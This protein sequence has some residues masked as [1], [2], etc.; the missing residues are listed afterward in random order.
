M[1]K[2]YR[3]ILFLVLFSFS[4]FS[5][6]L[7]LYCK[8]TYNDYSLEIFFSR[9]L[10][11]ISINLFFYSLI[12]LIDIEYYTQVFKI[13]LIVIASI[14]LFELLTWAYLNIIPISLQYGTFWEIL[15]F[16]SFS[17]IGQGLIIYIIYYINESTAKY[18][19][20]KVFGRYHL[21]EG[22]FGVLFIVIALILLILRSSLLFLSDIL[23]KRFSIILLLVQVFLFIFLYIGSFLIFRDWH[24]VRKFR[25]IDK[26]Y[27]DNDKSSVNQSSIFNQI[28]QDDLP[29]FEFPRLTY[30][31]FGIIL[32][33]FALNTIIYGTI[34]L[35]EEIFNLEN[36]IIILLGYLTSFIAGGLIGRDWLRLFRKLYPHLYEEL[37]IAINNLKNTM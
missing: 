23:W 16:I 10:I 25:F 12:F 33:I 11:L 20:S 15:Y 19:E 32:T 29:F 8:K 14:W 1:K 21:H 27:I 3:L 17:I 22:F 24:D 5:I 4:C 31:P 13:V 34:F 36:E 2:S 37:K 28:T 6:L 7:Y 9:I 26:K 35:P 18:S 30:Y